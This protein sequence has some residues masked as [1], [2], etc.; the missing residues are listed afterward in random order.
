MCG[1]FSYVGFWF[2][3]SLNPDQQRESHAGGASDRSDLRPSGGQELHPRADI[4]E[5]VQGEGQRQ[6][7]R[8]G[9]L[10]DRTG[11]DT[12]RQAGADRNGTPAANGGVGAAITAAGALFEL[13]AEAVQRRARELRDAMQELAERVRD[14]AERRRSLDERDQRSPHYIEQ[15]CRRL[16][17]GARD[18]E[19]GT[20]LIT[21][22]ADEVRRDHGIGL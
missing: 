10:N 21:D 3:C 13:F 15:E 7:G 19:A 22:M 4:R 1:Y 18:I 17:E 5:T 20:A 8:G 16:A 11:A 12:A 9:E 2:H 14:V 6:N